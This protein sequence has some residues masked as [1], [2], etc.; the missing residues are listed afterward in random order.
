MSGLRKVTIEDDSVA[1]GSEQ[2]GAMMRI[3]S[4]PL[5]IRLGLE[6]GLGLGIVIGL[7]LGIGFGLRSLLGLKSWLVFGLVSG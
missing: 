3:C 5:R 2:V 6:F 4:S 7:G 1:R